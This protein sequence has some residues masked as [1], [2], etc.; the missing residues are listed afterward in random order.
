MS[1][2]ST[3]YVFCFFR[4]VADIDARKLLFPHA[5]S[6]PEVPRSY[7][8]LTA[9]QMC[10]CTFCNQDDEV[11][12]LL[13]ECQMELAAASVRHHN[14]EDAL[15]L[16]GQLETSEAAWNQAQVRTSVVCD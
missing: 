10:N 11:Q 14:F 4:G 13:L 1:D 8:F 9:W 5:S 6:L 2:K 15:Q 12:E 3:V 7:F 16:Y